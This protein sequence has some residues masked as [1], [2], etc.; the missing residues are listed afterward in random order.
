MS[1]L[2]VIFIFAR[3]LKTFLAFVTGSHPQIGRL[4]M[5]NIIAKTPAANN[6]HNNIFAKKEKNSICI[7]TED[8]IK[9]SHRNQLSQRPYKGG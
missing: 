4:K 2:T 3:F 6:N 9:G 8:N 1:K 7:S 5:E